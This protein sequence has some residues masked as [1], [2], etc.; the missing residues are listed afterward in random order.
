MSLSANHIAPGVDL[1]NPGSNDHVPVLFQPHKIIWQ[2]AFVD[3]HKLTST[4][5]VTQTDEKDTELGNRAAN[6]PEAPT[7]SIQFDVTITQVD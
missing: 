3:G 7:I 6:D 5:E 1:A 2:W 4:W